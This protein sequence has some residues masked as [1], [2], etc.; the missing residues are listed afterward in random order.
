VLFGNT[1]KNTIPEIL[2]HNITPSVSDLD[3]VKAYS[4]SADDSAAPVFVKVDVGL[5]RLGVPYTEAL[6][7]FREISHHPNIR[8]DGIMTHIALPKEH[9]EKAFDRFCTVVTSLEKRGFN[10]PIKLAAHS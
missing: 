10:I 6:N 9:I 7:F 3:W 4:D 2:R 1:L 5:N 8:V